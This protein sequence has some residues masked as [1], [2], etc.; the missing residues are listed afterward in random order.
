[1]ISQLPYSHL[2]L[3]LR[4]YLTA[5]AVVLGIA[6]P[7]CSKPTHPSPSPKDLYL[8]LLPGPSQPINMSS[9]PA[10]QRNFHGPHVH[11]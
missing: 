6:C 2:K 8:T 9:P 7:S 1:M 10:L 4:T 11:L 3:F 5:F